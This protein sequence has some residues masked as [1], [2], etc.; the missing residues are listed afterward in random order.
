[1]SAT[2]RF[3]CVLFIALSAFAIANPSPLYVKTDGSNTADG[4]SWTTAFQTIQKAIDS[5]DN[6][7]EICVREGTYCEQLD[8]KG[9][10]LNIHS[11][12]LEDDSKLAP[13]T[14]IIDANKQGTAVL[15]RG[16]EKK[17][18]GIDEI[19]QLRG[20]TIH[21]GYPA[22][23]SLALYLK[24]DETGTETIAADD[25]GKEREG[26]LY[27]FDENSGWTTDP[28][29]GNV[30][31][32]DSV[33]DYIKISDYKGVVGA[34]LRTCSAWIK[35]SDT[36]ST[37]RSVISW[38]QNCSANRKW[39]FGLNPNGKL[40]VF[41]HSNGVIGDQ[42]L[43]D[44]NWH[45]IV[46]VLDNDGM[47][48][49]SDIKLYVD[50]REQTYSYSGISGYS[51]NTNP[52]DVYIGA[53]DYEGSTGLGAWFKGQ[54]DDI[55][56][57]SRPLPESEIQGLVLSGPAACWKLDG[58][59][60]DSS[61]NA[62]DLSLNGNTSWDT[63]LF[64]QALV[65]DG[66]DDYAEAQSNSLLNFTDA[67]TLSAWVKPAADISDFG[68][69]I[70]RYDNDSK[71][72]YM[73][74]YT[75]SSWMFYVVVNNSL[76]AVAGNS[77]PR[78]G[79]W[80]HV[81]GRRSQNGL[82]ELFIDGIKQPNSAIKTGEINSSG[83]L[84]LGVDYLY[85]F[86]FKGVIDEVSIYNRAINDIEI[87]EQ[88]RQRLA[89]GGGIRG[90][91]TQADITHCVVKHNLSGIEGGG[92][93]SCNGDIA[94]CV[95]A[96][97]IARN[98]GAMNECNGNVINCTIADSAALFAGGGLQNCNGAVVNTILW[99]NRDNSG[100]SQDAQIRDCNEITY[101]CIQGW[102][103]G[104]AGNINGNPDFVNS[105]AEDYHLDAASVCINAGNP[106]LSYTGQVDLDGNP[107]TKG[108]NLRIDHGAY[109]YRQTI[110]YVDD[111]AAGDSDPNIPDDTHNEDG[112]REHPY[113]S[114]QQ[115][116]DAISSPGDSN[117]VVV[118]NGIYTG[119]GNRDIDFGG[120][121]ITIRSQ[122]GPEH[123][124]IDC[125]G[126]DTEPHRGFFFHSSETLESVVDGFTITRGNANNSDPN[127]PVSYYD[128]S[129]GA[130]A[131]GLYSIQQQLS[132]S[133]LIKNCIIKNSKADTHG[134][135]VFCVSG[136][137][138]NIIN[139]IFIN[140]Q[141]QIFGGGLYC[142][143][144]SNA[145]IVNSTFVDN[146]GED[147]GAIYA[148]QSN[149][150][151]TN[152][153]I[154]QN[155][156]LNCDLQVY[157]STPVVTYNFVEGGYAGI[158]N[159]G[160]FPD[161]NP[162]FVDPDG[163]DNIYG[164]FDDNCR[165]SV[166][167]PC[168]DAGTN[169]IT[170]LTLQDK[171]MSGLQR[172]V[173]G[174]QNGSLIVDMGAYEYQVNHAPV[175]N[176]D[177]EISG[178]LLE[179]TNG[180]V[181]INLLAND[182]DAD[183]DELRICSDP[184]LLIQPT[185]GTAEVTNNGL[186]VTYAPEAG[187]SGIDTFQYKA[188]D[189]QLTSDWAT[190]TVMV[191]QTQIEYPPV[192]NPDTA[193]V[194]M[195]T[196]VEIDVLENDSD[197]DPGDSLSVQNIVSGSGP[198][199]G[200]AEITQD[201]VKIRYTPYKAD[202]VNDTFTYQIIDSTGKTAQA[203]VTVLVL[204]VD[205]GP[206]RDAFYSGNPV[207]LTL[208]GH[209][210]GFV[211]PV[212]PI[213]QWNCI[214]IKGTG[215]AYIDDDDNIDNDGTTQTEI[216]FSSE[217]TYLFELQVQEDT[218]GDGIGDG[219]ML[220]DYV[221]VTI[222]QSMAYNTAPIVMAWEKAGQNSTSLTREISATVTDDGK[223]NPDG[224]LDVT[225]MV[226]ESDGGTV[227]FGQYSAD[228]PN[229]MVTFSRAGHYILKLTAE[230]GQNT[231]ETYVQIIIEGSV[232]NNAPVVEIEKETVV[233]F[234][235]SLVGQSSVSMT[236]LTEIDVSDA[237]G[238]PLS[239][240]WAISGDLSDN[241]YLSNWNIYNPVLTFVELD[242]IAGRTFTLNLTAYDGEAI[243]SDS[244]HIFVQS[245][246]GESGEELIIDAGA[247]KLVQLPQ[248]YDP[249]V[250]VPMEDANSLPSENV[251]YQWF[252]TGVKQG[253][254]NIQ[255]GPMEYHTPDSILSISTELNPSIT[256]TVP[257]LYQFTIKASY[258]RA[259]NIEI[260]SEDTVWVT[261]QPGEPL[262]PPKV[263]YVGCTYIP[264]DNDPQRYDIEGAEGRVLCVHPYYGQYV[265]N[266]SPLGAYVNVLY[267]YK[268]E[269]YAGSTGK[270]R[271]GGDGGYR[272]PERGY[273]R[274]WRMNG[275]QWEIIGDGLGQNVSVMTEYD[276]LL[277]AGA[278]GANGFESGIV[279]GKSSLYSYDGIQWKRIKESPWPAYSDN[280]ISSM[281]EF[282]NK[283]F[284]GVDISGTFGRID[285]Y[286]GVNWSSV[287]Y[288]D[289]VGYFK[290]YEQSLY[291]M[292]TGNNCLVRMSPDEQ[293]EYM[294]IDTS[295]LYDIDVCM[296]MEVYN[297]QLY[298]ATD[299][300]LCKYTDPNMGG[301]GL[302]RVDP[303]LLNETNSLLIASMISFDDPDDGINK[304]L[305]GT[306]V[307]RV[308][309]ESMRDNYIGKIIKFN[310]VDPA[311]KISD[312]DTFYGCYITSL[313][314]SQIRPPM[315]PNE[316]DFR[317]TVAGQ[318]IQ[319][320]DELTYTI[321]SD[322]PNGFP[323]V[324]E[325]LCIVDYLPREVDFLEAGFNGVYNE[326]NH[327]V[328][329]Y[330]GILEARDTTLINNNDLSVKVR[331]NENAKPGG[332]I[333]N[334]Y[335]IETHHF[336][337]TV[338]CRTDIDDWTGNNVVYVD[339][340]SPIDGGGTSWQ[341]AYH[342]LQQALHDSEVISAG[343]RANGQD[344]NMQIWVA[345]GT[346]FPAEHD[347]GDSI[348][349]ATFSLFDGVKIYGGFAGNETAIEQRN[350]TYNDNKTYLTGKGVVDHVVS[351]IADA[352]TPV[353]NILLD[354]LIITKGVKAGVYCENISNMTVANCEITENDGYIILQDIP[355]RYPMGGILCINSSPLIE[356]NIISLNNHAGIYCEEDCNITIQRNQLYLNGFR[357][358]HDI[359][360]NPVGIYL[361]KV[362]GMPVIQN[363]LLYDHRYGIFIQGSDGLIGEP[364]TV[365]LNAV[366]RNNTVIYNDYSPIYSYGYESGIEDVNISVYNC[367]LWPNDGEMVSNQITD[368]QY[369]I[370]DSS[371][372]NI[373]DP[374]Q[375]ELWRHN[376]V[377]YDRNSNEPQDP[378]SS[379]IYS[380]WRKSIVIS[381]TSTSNSFIISELNGVYN[382]GDIIQ[383]GNEV[384]PRYVTEI[385]CQD[386]SDNK[387]IH[388]KPE[389]SLGSFDEVY[390]WGQCQEVK[391]L[392]DNLNNVDPNLLNPWDE[393]Y[394]THF[395]EFL[396]ISDNLDSFTTTADQY[397]LYDLIEINGPDGESQ[398]AC[399]IQKESPVK[400]FP[401]RSF[402]EIASVTNWSRPHPLAMAFK[403]L[404]VER[405]S[406][407]KND[408][409][410]PCIDS[411]DPN[412]VIPEH[413]M[414]PVYQQQLDID[415]NPRVLG[416]SIDIGADEITDFAVSIQEG[417][418]QVNPGD[419]LIVGEIGDGDAQI[420]RKITIWDPNLTAYECTWSVISGDESQV[421]W[422]GSNPDITGVSFSKA[423][424][425]KLKVELRETA[426]EQKF[427]GCDVIEC[428]VG[429]ISDAYV[430]DGSES[431]PTSAAEPYETYLSYN[432]QNQAAEAV[433]DIFAVIKGTASGEAV[434]SLSDYE[435]SHSVQDNTETINGIAVPTV[436]VVGKVSLR[437]TGRHT[438]KLNIR[439]NNTGYSTI[440]VYIEVKQPSQGIWIT[441]LSSVD[442][443]AY[444]GFIT[445][446]VHSGITGTF[447]QGTTMR[448]IQ[449]S[450]PVN[451]P[452]VGLYYTETNPGTRLPDNLISFY[453][454][455]DYCIAL[456]AV[457]DNIVLSCAYLNVSVSG[458]GLTPIVEAGWYEPCVLDNG[459]AQIDLVSDKTWIRNFGESPTIQWSVSPAVGCTISNP[460]ILTPTV[461]FT[462]S[463]Q[464][465]FT[466]SVN[467]P[468]QN[469]LADT[470]T[471]KVYPANS[472][473][474]IVDAGQYEPIAVGQVLWLDE[475]FVWASDM[476]KIT[477]KWTGDGD[478]TFTPA[479]A[480]SHESAI[481]QPVV[482]FGTLGYHTL[483][484][485]VWN[486]GQLVIE[487]TTVIS[488][489]QN[490][491]II[492]SVPPVVDMLVTHDGRR[493]SDYCQLLSTDSLA[494]KVNAS[495]IGSGLDN[496]SLKLT[497]NG[498]DT[499]LKTKNN[500]ADGTLTYTLNYNN[501]NLINYSGDYVLT[502]YAV[503]KK[504]NSA[505]PQEFNF[506]VTTE[507]PDHKP[508]AL[509]SN[510]PLREFN[511]EQTDE[512]ETRPCN[513]KESMFEVHGLAYH[514]DPTWTNVKYKLEV[515]KEEAYYYPL[516]E[517][518]NLDGYGTEPKYLID[519]VLV[520]ADP[521]GFIAA[522]VTG[523]GS[524]PL[525]QINLTGIPNGTYC[526]LLTVVA[527]KEGAISQSYAFVKFVLDSPLKIGNVKFSQEDVAIPVGGVS[528]QVIR[529]YDSF[530]KDKSGEFG[531]GWDYSI[532][533]IDIQ[534]NEYRQTLQPSYAEDE[535]A[536]EA[537]V[538]VGS[539]YDR[540]VTL[541]L[542]DGREAMFEFYLQQKT[543]DG[544]IPYYLAKYRAPE[545]VGAT[546]ETFQKDD[547]S[548]PEKLIFVPYSNLIGWNG[549]MVQDGVK[550][551]PAAHD[552]G[553]YRLTTEDGTQYVFQREEV[554]SEAGV[555][556]EHDEY[557]NYWARPLG[558]PYLS[559][560]ITATGEKIAL[561]VLEST[562]QIGKYG[563]NGIE[564]YMPNATAPT[565]AIKLEYDGQG[566]IFEIYAPS[567]Q[568]SGIPTVWYEYGDNAGNLTAVY[569]LTQKG[570]SKA[571]SAYEKLSYEYQDA[572]HYPSDHYITAIKDPRGLSPIQYLYDDAGRLIGTKD[573]KGNTISIAHNITDRTEI[574]TDRAGNPTIY[575][576]DPKGNVKSVTDCQG[577]TTTYT[578]DSDNPLKISNVKTTTTQ[579]P[580]YDNPGEILDSTTTYDYVY[581]TI[582]GNPGYGKLQSQTVT[583]PVLNRTVTV[584]DTS[585][586]VTST[587]QKKWDDGQQAFVEVLT[588][589]TK[590][591][592][593]NLPY[594]T[595]TTTTD[596]ATN[597]TTWH[598]ISLT[599]YDDKNRVTYSVQIN[600]DDVTY[601]D[602]FNTSG[603]LKSY[604]DLASL[605]ATSSVTFYHYF[606][607]S[608]QIGYSPDQPSYIVGPDGQVQLFGYDENNKQIASWNVFDDPF[609]TDYCEMSSVSDFDDAGRVVRN[610]QVVANTTGTIT[611][612]N[613]VLS[614]TFY[615][616]L[617]KV[618]YTLDENG[619]K[620]VFDYDE[621]GN[622]VQ[623]SVFQSVEKPDPQ[624]PQQT[625]LVYEPLTIT[626]TLYDKNDRVLV[627]V[628]AFDAANPDARPTGTETVYD[629][630]GR[631]FMTRQWK[632]VH[633][634]L[635]RFKVNV[636]GQKVF[637]SQAE[638][639]SIPSDPVGM[640]VPSTTMA[641]NAWDGTGTQPSSIGWTAEDVL[642][643]AD[644]EAS[645]SETV[646]DSA[647]RVWKTYTMKTDRTMVCTNEYT[648]DLA[649]RQVDVITLPGDPDETV[650]T[651]EYDGARRWKVTD[652]RDKTTEFIYDSLGRVVTTQYNESTSVT[653]LNPDRS[654]NTQTGVTYVHVGYDGLGRKVWES[655]R[656]A[657]ERTAVDQLTDAD[658]ATVCK[659]FV[660]SMAG[661]LVG[662]TLASDTANR[663]QYDYFYDTYGNQIGILDPQGQL[664]I[665]I[666]NYRRQP[667]YRY[668]PF[669]PRTTGG[670]V[671]PI[672]SSA[673]I[674]A[675]DLS[676]KLYTE[677]H[678]DAFDRLS[679]EI[680][681]EGQ[682]TV[683]SYYDSST[684]V[685]G[686]E[687]VGI[688]GALRCK[689]YY[690]AVSAIPTERI[691]FY[692]DTLG[693]K[694]K[695][696]MVDVAANGTES[697]PHQWTYDYDTDGS[698]KQILLP[699]GIAVNY[700]YY[701]V[702]GQKEFTRTD[703]TTNKYEYD[704]L[705]RLQN[706]RA[707]IRGGQALSPTEVTSYQYDANG[708][709][710]SITLQN[711]IFTEY[712]YNELNGLTNLTH[713]RN[714]GKVE[715]QKVGSYTYQQYA[716]GMRARVVEN[717]N[718]NHVIT[719][720][721]DAR[722][723]LT[724][725]QNYD[726]NGYGYTA[727]YAY[728]LNGNRESRA[729]EVTN[730]DYT[731]TLTTA[732]DYYPDSNRLYT[733]TVSA[734]G[735]CAMLPWG[736]DGKAFVYRAGHGYSFQMPDQIHRL[737][738]IGAMFIGLPSWW[739]QVLF[740]A[741]IVLIPVSLF[742][743]VFVK[744][745]KKLRG[746]VDTQA[747]P[748]LKLWQRCMCVLLA[749]VFF[750]TPDGFV[751][752]SQ[753]AIQYGDL[754]TA[755]WGQGDTTIVY[756]YDNNGS[757]TKKTTKT[758][759]TQA[760]REVVDYT[761]NLQGK[762]K[763]V[764]TNK[765]DG[766]VEVAQYVYAPSG[767]R[768]RTTSWLEVSG[769][770]GSYQ[771]K[772]FVVDTANPTGYSQVLE[773]WTYDVQNPIYGTTA[774]VSV[775]YYTIGDDVISQAIGS[776]ISA[777]TAQYLLYDGHGST[778]QL[779]NH[780]YNVDGTGK[781]ITS[782]S[783]SY[784][785][786]GV[787]LGSAA[788]AEN[789]AQAR[790]LY[791]GEQY[792]K[793]LSQYY[794]RARYY[795]PLNGLFNQ[796]D[797][798]AGSMTD[799]QSL[800]KYLY[801]HCNP[802]NN[803]DPSGKFIG[804]LVD[805]MWAMA[806]RA[807]MFAD[808][809]GPKIFAGIWAITKI[810][811][812]LWLSCVT[813]MILQQIG[814][815]PTCEYVNEIF[816]ILNVVLMV[817]F[818]ILT[819]LPPE[820]QRTP[821]LSSVRSS[822]LRGMNDPRV[823]QAADVGN[824]VH[825]DKITD[826]TK[827]SHEG[828]PSQLKN[829]YKDT[830]FY[831]AKRGQ[832]VIDVTVIG[833]RHPSTYPNSKWPAGINKADFKP[834]TPSG[835]AYKLSPNALKILYDP[836]TGQLKH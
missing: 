36:V 738:E 571:N 219:L 62:L 253:G 392:I 762:L 667:V 44:N 406:H 433:V 71:D 836:Q 149:P 490:P 416:E 506:H 794:L 782:D 798:Y 54:M 331:V 546:L 127:F 706:V 456:Q 365:G 789:N 327:T 520:G 671:I 803:I 236:D 538:R 533:G 125:D 355:G 444:S 485:A 637:E 147:G 130:I 628:T 715:A 329:W 196:S 246:D 155:T 443:K 81:A 295:L 464:Y 468:G 425:Y 430:I 793:N 113:D 436:T 177:P 143:L 724:E 630:L 255:I 64:G 634:N 536:I 616:N 572:T 77:A 547:P 195:G 349:D 333:V 198:T 211:A 766:T 281:S 611:N 530:Q 760:I 347:M 56:I 683:Y 748:R 833:G 801:C 379:R 409:N 481:I 541:T 709:R 450:G 741:V 68:R 99:N 787:M 703:K 170:D 497:Y 137:N 267:E 414:Y 87:R 483:T 8:F 503:D 768:Y 419:S 47:S 719:Y 359:D 343:R 705:S 603:T 830:D 39:V 67:F 157:E 257:G 248:S 739:N 797:P 650:T 749:Y 792:D 2:S 400:Y 337:E 500:F 816:A 771:T 548:S 585:G 231:T 751:H 43:T 675:L 549:I 104:G 204:G 515:F 384:V 694:T 813:N 651:T 268:S 487:K 322:D 613:R 508:V 772:L 383:I 821:T 144:N 393:Q 525:G 309:R 305:L 344:P 601:A 386:G 750:V 825:Y 76:V 733:E 26:I 595:G 790:L 3:Y 742:W 635:Q 493:L 356:D 34:G 48:T 674:Y 146:R 283:L 422:F 342:D 150:V 638:Y 387:T 299:L 215:T 279:N 399:V 276:G 297:G 756:E 553:G 726:T 730:A 186:T 284:I 360:T 654:A 717:V 814:V 378:N 459:S 437:T 489:E 714:T 614:Q 192:A 61:D 737:G 19:A 453:R 569:K 597:A 111:N 535:T 494:V 350:L 475:A 539:N 426:P 799:P 752:L 371:I 418:L 707:M 93:S 769:T 117:E 505:I 608:L 293:I 261:V 250:I 580:D 570:T 161:N 658:H 4:Q 574:V 200:K 434:F 815:L 396:I 810:T 313:L 639:A 469:P 83:K 324:Q 80:T 652:G 542:P 133:P 641:A 138:A 181:T 123:C 795:N 516:D 521:N 573:A 164:T 470:M 691:K 389:C 243:G 528:L 92:L 527:Q 256:F 588:T 710:K 289:R 804:P 783:Y 65:L 224:F 339:D 653:T 1:M 517:W 142:K 427:L 292:N 96:K 405:Y 341:T 373:Y 713:W 66:S 697:N 22:Q 522:S 32:F 817:E 242:K 273:G 351:V 449:V 394:G 352:N 13:D 819:S 575:E 75:P 712:S 402:E 370:I 413:P 462:Q 33:D 159:K 302:V 206:N 194:A 552:F 398:V 241:L 529:T 128:G 278:E 604:D 492:D 199:K 221:E 693:R 829:I 831:F 52:G 385:V 252:W 612:I 410:N 648:Y 646:Y 336:F 372:Y 190:V 606:T 364:I 622:A 78:K 285:W 238:D 682:K 245:G 445:W 558:K 523:N 509:I 755:S 439:D 598:S 110:W 251:T 282:N 802:I 672:T 301:E 736:G 375:T 417:T 11:C 774:P 728:D 30:L 58:N 808:D 554:T 496:V 435:W 722:N 5:A 593:N 237:D 226:E 507:D 779:L 660:Y 401:P 315:P 745:L 655:Q 212:S 812:A 767:D 376:Q 620:T 390:N 702:T 321:Q 175:A 408:P 778:R 532:I 363:N 160:E 310:G 498:T 114:I 73:I 701:A 732:Y 45:H 319:P 465:T 233:Y 592:T 42:V 269:L 600:M 24:L 645:R 700:D 112:S 460:A 294:N 227:A 695:E 447:P 202:G 179:C 316:F 518:K 84:F 234:I 785:G 274:V 476:S 318:N 314:Q 210:Y 621:T 484:L 346:Y 35:T 395:K 388:F 429:L 786:Y 823:K 270:C 136:S 328:T 74:T 228:K 105:K 564:H 46:T 545:G 617:G 264:N 669:V 818:F 298:L 151:I 31:T 214:Y 586:N 118:L 826:P 303:N 88:Y 168:I 367:L 338:E 50:G 438:L 296:P 290:R 16:N 442:K 466:L 229:T 244:I 670:A 183:G 729:V 615:T 758:T 134:G 51:I 415:G 609:S 397:R 605:L 688:A 681:C 725:E 636:Q 335:E 543:D 451:A 448:W 623:T 656:T 599:Y 334:Q 643:V 300:N 57:Y 89:F 582:P 454:N 602:L 478:S 354:G 348:T 288:D 625:I 633:L 627:S 684:C 563:D 218:N 17:G 537:S 761:Y 124:V 404:K 665:T 763:E 775:K 501:L 153:I 540:D 240:N 307:G 576:Y 280:W 565:K 368:F 173:D 421:Y 41:T 380:N 711:G 661:Q 835:N 122:S 560:I 222:S 721:Y 791:C 403:R 740:Y 49:I 287:D 366:I 568:G 217:G 594:L 260:T 271:Y 291:W 764:R 562:L 172:I 689:D 40:C 223:G 441:P 479:G 431:V 512:I 796:M 664:T 182:S 526:L 131:C 203:D 98:A 306:G 101:S 266:K 116:I 557:E 362:S 513:I 374:H 820:W 629:A 86:D 225:W 550:F 610:R 407:L 446:Q 499:Y 14:T 369:C 452:P 704:S 663:P 249:N 455:G 731:C 662:V 38:G 744:Q 631:A 708:N 642:P 824:R 776:D 90:N 807:K 191:Q 277:Y 25:S 308:A 510:M 7:R 102:T 9:K 590:Y 23:D 607:D 262:S 272:Y 185:H 420:H 29:Q 640:S 109:E 644:S 108:R 162:G 259:D 135:G 780:A 806:I 680:D 461:T 428:R 716:S 589:Q 685:E 566:R 471:V 579:V 69:I 82:L 800:H 145:K 474:L 832:K 457:N 304:L 753:A 657:L 511:N 70:Y 551:D 649:G 659:D 584:F 275:S 626:Q 502:A 735:L 91:G 696:I 720:Q 690:P 647:G 6:G 85:N 174:D 581:Y 412:S 666:Y 811:I 220:E 357:P 757:M 699:D 747:P 686:N 495:D 197:Q 727:S 828:A 692:Y 311:E 20:F 55:K 156:S 358:I 201:G 723:Q 148:F 165:L 209:C 676:G 258:I 37:Y 10:N 325:R 632:N 770:P 106:N 27:N 743:P 765:Q 72:G 213:V 140:N 97:N 208:T 254:A 115:A 759:S 286:D 247:N 312:D 618:N 578:Y 781:P 103:G 381:G 330:L 514:P 188:S 544:P 784:D 121:A 323:F 154:W 480:D 773:E 718:E 619:N 232:T 534:L 567:E 432:P 734:G 377:V 809:V 59:A 63:S 18:E 382:E 587:T 326:P 332:Q 189:G 171:D 440:P 230:D 463:G 205:A 79:V 473:E 822:G 531:Y 556:Y 677:F 126:S 834:D 788:N 166:N 345:A 467:N 524:N 216:T 777:G 472:G 21:N 180:T 158:G 391:D 486:D 176:D 167:S 596:S 95:I 754:S 152:N 678:Y 184:N 591:T 187:Y 207:S 577:H 60:D 53:Y 423:G 477:V 504:P 353:D 411:G 668:M 239:L 320:S 361:N 583:D 139:C 673:D 28:N 519:K 687:W 15:F 561:N 263:L 107:R 235:N 340:D 559:E 94:N 193:L 178:Q 424:I 141:A 805:V 698:L 624:N 265:I 679:Y 317:V 169:T 129:G 488:V 120:K 746:S 491:G 119:D 12:D 827:Y 132:A 458:V 482:S 163:A 555:Y 100:I